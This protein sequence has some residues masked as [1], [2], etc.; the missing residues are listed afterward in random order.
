MKTAYLALACA[1]LEA[2]TTPVKGHIKPK[3]GTYV[4]P[5][6]RSSP[7][8]TQRDN[9]ESKGNANPR[10]GKEGTKTPKK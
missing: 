8:K 4:E 7:N 6:V 1:F 2:K 9:Y 3:T 5:H 10:T